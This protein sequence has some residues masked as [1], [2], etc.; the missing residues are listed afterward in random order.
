MGLGQPW[1]TSEVVR[2]LI[3]RLRGDG[4]LSSDK[5]CGSGEFVAAMHMAL[6]AA[7]VGREKAEPPA[8]ADVAKEFLAETIKAKAGT[9]SERIHAASLLLGVKL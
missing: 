1:E 7:I 6:N 4:W 9:L 8:P 3:E 2:M 5:P